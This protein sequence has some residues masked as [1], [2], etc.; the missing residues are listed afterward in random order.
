MNSANT[1]S[2]IAR[3]VPDCTHPFAS[4]MNEDIA[5]V[6]TLIGVVLLSTLM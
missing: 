5:N 6:C 1:R 3:R 4:V 2:V